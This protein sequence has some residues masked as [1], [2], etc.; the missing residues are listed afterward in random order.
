MLHSACR[1]S[2]FNHL[3]T[4]YRKHLAILAACSLAALFASSPAFAHD[5]DT[6]AATKARHAHVAKPKVHHVKRTVKASSGA[7]KIAARKPVRA[8]SY[9]STARPTVK[10]GC[11]PAQAPGQSECVCPEQEVSTAALLSTGEWERLR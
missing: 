11:A 2:V 4:M 1:Q 6:P 3:I 8:K 5:C 9:A 10:Q 7:H